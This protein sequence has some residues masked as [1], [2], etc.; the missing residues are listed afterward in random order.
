M[1]HVTLALLIALAAGCVATPAPTPACTDALRD[2]RAS[3]AAHGIIS[4]MGGRDAE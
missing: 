1:R 3:Q 4:Q 2:Y